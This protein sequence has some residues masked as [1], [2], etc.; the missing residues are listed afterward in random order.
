MQHIKWEDLAG[1]YEFWIFIW[2]IKTF[3]QLQNDTSFIL[4]EKGSIFFLFF[5]IFWMF[6]HLYLR[7][8]KAA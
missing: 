4:I 3:S 2:C 6:K 8:P 5:I 1:K 7:E